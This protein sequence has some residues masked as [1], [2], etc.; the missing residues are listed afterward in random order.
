LAEDVEAGQRHS[1]SSCNSKGNKIIFKDFLRGSKIGCE[2][3]DQEFS[4]KTVPLTSGGL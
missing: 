2:L 4:I 1:K 3:F